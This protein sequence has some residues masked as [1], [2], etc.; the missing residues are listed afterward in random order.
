MKKII[1]LA[2]INFFLL[3]T[4]LTYS[5]SN[6]VAISNGKTTSLE[7]IIDNYFNSF[8]THEPFSGVVLVAKGDNIVFHKGY[9]FAN[10]E[11][12]IL[13]SPE[14]RFQI[15][16][17]TKAFTGILVVKMVELGLLDLNKTIS[18]YLPYYPKETGRK[19]TI[20]NLLSCTSGIP[21][22]YE[23]IPDYF[24]SHDHYFHSPKELLSLFWNIPLKHEP[25]AEWTY[26]SPGFYILGAILQQVSK[27]SYAELLQ[28]YIFTPLNMKSTF[29][30]N[31]RTTDKNLAT[32]YYRGLTGPVKAYVEDKSTALAAGDIISTAYDLYLWQKALN[33]NGDNILSAESKKILFKP[34]L[35]T[36]EMT[37]IGPQ[38]SIPYDEGSKNLTLGIL[39]GSS[40]GYSSYLSRFIEEDVCVIVL[41]NIND[42]EVNR[43]GDDIGDFYLRHFLN[44]A[45][46]PVAP[47]TRI[48]PLPANIDKSIVDRVI[49]FYRQSEGNY[50]GTIRDGEKYYSLNY[51]K[52]SGINRTMELIPFVKDTFYLSHDNRFRCVF[53]PDK[54]DGTLIMSSMRKGRTFAKAKR[55]ELKETIDKEYEGSFTSLELQKTTRFLIGSNALIADSLLGKSNVKLTYLEK[56]LFGF[57][58]GFIEFER[59]KDGLITDFVVHTKDTDRGF[60]SRW[61]KIAY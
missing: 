37:Y 44:I 54:N 57:E 45:I 16:S 17:I 36:M 48:A 11:F 4:Q 40:S 39:N 10:R 2:S 5:Q 31:N 14:T 56:D 21:H 38:Y 58:F 34:V 47:F 46:G 18:D 26:S 8:P 59:D 29:V 60:G 1:L 49:G 52:G 25:G 3:S 6:T 51:I 15:G 50:F 19:I 35:P 53:A 7:E 9:N 23:A 24:T 33:Y 41:S 30:E 55:Y 22:H 42:A 20:N 43:I 32:G 12:G 28:E 61:I 27:K 13:N